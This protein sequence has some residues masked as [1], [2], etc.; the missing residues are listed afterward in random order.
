MCIMGWS[1]E[2]KV[3]HTGADPGFSEGAF[4]FVSAESEK[5][6]V[7]SGGM[8]PRENLK[9]WNVGDAISWAFR[10]NLRQKGGSTKLIEPPM[11]QP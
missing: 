8:L 2:Y 9:T 10:V 7:G 5:M 6:L 1:T 3:V 4:D 11:D